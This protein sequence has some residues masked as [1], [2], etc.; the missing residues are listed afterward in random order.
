MPYGNDVTVYVE[1]VS[2]DLGAPPTATSPPWWI[3]PD[4]L[5]P[6][7][8]GEAS[9]GPN[10][11]Q[12]R[13]HANDEPV[14]DQKILTEVYV[15]NP[16][17]VMSPSSGTKR[18]DDGT[19]VFRTNAVPGTEPVA[20]VA[21]ATLTFTW[22][23]SSTAGAIDGAGHRCLVLRAFPANVTP[24]GDPFTV[25]TEQHEAQHNIEILTTTNA[26]A[27]APGGLPGAGTPHDPRRRD[28]STGMWWEQFAT[29][30][31]TGSGRRFVV[32]AFDPRPD[33]R[34]IPGLHKA[35]ARA[36]VTISEQPP[37]EVAIEVVGA[38][39]GDIDP[40]ELLRDGP[41]VE[42]SGLGTGLF[43]A[44]RLLRA[45]QLDLGRRRGPRLVL[46]F[47][48]SNLQPRTAVVLHGA[49]WDASGVPEGGMTVVVLAPTGS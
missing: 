1:D 12:I 8:P 30:A 31:P 37:R 40:A 42:R 19:L 13:V 21:G 43:A 34:L 48:H 44:D 46:R 47:D 9:Q 6:A 38:K 14:L 49:Q 39:G 45:A 24:P 41:F 5:I 22:T 2:G 23:P 10:T 4:V 35:L 26:F 28:K 17:L 20:N 32:W 18:I 11:V 36:H 15:G 27:P 29:M 3:S 7:H 16:G 25:P 33:E